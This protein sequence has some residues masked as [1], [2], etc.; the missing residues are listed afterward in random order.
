ME[1]MPEFFENMQTR[2]CNYEKTTNDKR[3]NLITMFIK[4]GIT[5]KDA[6]NIL[7]IKYSTGRSIVRS[8]RL[9]GSSDLKSKGGSNKR[10]LSEEVS[11]KIENM[12][13]ENQGLSLKEMKN[14]LERD[15]WPPFKIS[16]SSIDRCLNSLCITL[17]KTHRV[18]DIVNSPEKVNQRKE[19]SLWFNN[20]FS[21]DYSKVIFVDESSFNLHLQ[22]SYGRSR[23]GERA[24]VTI[25][26]VRGRS[27]S[28]ISSINSTR[29]CFSKV[30]SESTVNGEVFATYLSELCDYLKNTLNM[31]EACIILDN[32]RVHRP[33]D[34]ARITEEY[35]FEFN[36][37]SPYSYMLNPIENAFSKI[38][39]NLRSK[40]R[41]GEQGSLQEMV[42][43]SVETVN[44]EDCSGY[45]RYMARNIT[46]CAAGLPYIH[47]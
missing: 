12:I 33:Q 19:Y 2:S 34:L 20:N 21:M 8:F 17:K 44:S 26:A 5:I 30:I 37:L 41:Q 45:F 29:I 27:V 13:S 43:S 31:Q 6:S 28:L 36:F 16:L 1:Q 46:N 7:K 42:I 47:H 18:L 40:L 4:E 35:G 32:A 10:V 25:P 15:I 9:N 3:Q 23:I 24:N 11:D 14:M 38:K 22:R 39:N